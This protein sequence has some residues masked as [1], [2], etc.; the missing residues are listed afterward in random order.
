MWSNSEA[1]FAPL[2]LWAFWAFVLDAFLGVA[3]DVVRAGVVGAVDDFPLGALAAASFA[4]AGEDVALES[5]GGELPLG[6]AL[7]L[8]M[9]NY[10]FH[11]CGEGTMMS[12]R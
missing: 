6:A 1:D 11:L 12:W 9:A 3:G 10:Q 4:L 7:R 2:D 8:T 5:E